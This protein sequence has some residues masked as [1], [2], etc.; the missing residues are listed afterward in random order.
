MAKH[1]LAIWS[2]LKNV[3]SESKFLDILRKNYLL[4]HIDNATRIRGGD[5]PH[6]LELVLSNEPFINN[7]EYLSLLGKSDHSVL[8]IFICAQ[9][10][11]SANKDK[12]NY[13]KADYDGLRKSCAIN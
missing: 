3:G 6:I 1:R 13:A 5:K 11:H 9:V 8:N 7:I 4:Q 12:Y 2:T 10:Q